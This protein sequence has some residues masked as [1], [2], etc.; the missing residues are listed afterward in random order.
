MKA[1]MAVFLESPSHTFKF[2]TEAGICF[3]MLWPGDPKE[4]EASTLPPVA[5]HLSPMGGATLT[6]GGHEP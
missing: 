5:L 2:P 1:R 4:T 3:E 6:R